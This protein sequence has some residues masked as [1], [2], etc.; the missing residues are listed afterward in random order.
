MLKPNVVRKEIGQYTYN[1]FLI[2][3]L[4]FPLT[5][6]SS[7]RAS[8]WPITKITKSALQWNWKSEEAAWI[9]ARDLQRPRRWHHLLSFHWLRLFVT[10]KSKCDAIESRRGLIIFRT[11]PIV[12]R[13]V[14]ALVL[15]FLLLNTSS[16]L[17]CIWNRNILDRISVARA[18]PFI[19]HNIWPFPLNYKNDKNAK[20]N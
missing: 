17:T 7:V 18:K 20:D 16:F 9:L 19:C 14:I 8:R 3:F 13:C 4:T 10:E 11:S 2:K 5:R 6:T 15:C 1:W 12:G